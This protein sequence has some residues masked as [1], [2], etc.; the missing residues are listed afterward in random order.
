MPGGVYLK[1][2]VGTNFRLPT[3]EELFADDPADERGNPKLKPE[4]S[5]SANL[6]LGGRLEM[7][8]HGLHWE[9]T[10]FARDV[11][12][13]I[14]LDTFDT[15]T[16][17]DVFGNVAGIVRTRGMQ[18]LVDANFTDSLSGNLNYTYN[19]TVDDSGDQL[20]RIPLALFKGGLD[21]HPKDQPWGATADLVYTG[22]AFRTVA[23]TDVSYGGYVVVDLS[24]RYFLDRDRRQTVNF[25]IRNLFDKT[26]GLPN[27]GCRDTAADGPFDCSIPYTYVNLGL[28]RTFAASYRYAF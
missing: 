22:D 14:D 21:Y 11:Q 16:N 4:R 13:L 15:V 20:A 28:P 17:Q 7:V 6:S 26:Y 5:I 25:S 27:K 18:A 19:H 9:I 2:E 3:A 23:G 10:G 8:G 12:D 24:A 1:G